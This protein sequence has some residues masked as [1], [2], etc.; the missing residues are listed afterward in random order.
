VEHKA[1]DLQGSGDDCDARLIVEGR[2]KKGIRV[3]IPDYQKLMLPVLKL[4]AEGEW[5]VP[6]AAEKIA[7]QFGLTI[8]EREEMLPSGRQRV[9][10]NRIHWA[11]F[12]L[13]KAGLI[14]SPQRGLFRATKAGKTALAKSPTHIDNDTLKAHPAFVEFHEASAAG[15]PKAEKPATAAAAAFLATPEEQIDA[16]QAVL[17]SALSSDLLQRILGNSP[18]F[19]EHLI[20]DLLGSRLIHS[21][22]ATAV[23]MATAERKLSASLS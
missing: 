6:K 11:K 5:R 2:A 1:N 13:S 3:A 20:V 9:L 14:E 17:H 15:Q 23:A 10:H 19:F 22:K 21:Q 8:D 18:L 4:A 16:A 7:N 12:Y